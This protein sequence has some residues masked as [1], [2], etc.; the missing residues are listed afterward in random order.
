MR[1]FTYVTL[2]IVFS[3]VTFTNGQILNKLKKA[4]KDGVQE[5]VERRV[6]H[7]I[8]KAAQKQTDKYLEQLFGA[9]TQYEGGNYDYGEIMKNFNMNVDHADSYSFTGY[10]DMEISGT[11]QKGKAIDPTMFRSFNN[12][13]EQIW[14]MELETDEK[15][16][17]KTIMIFDNNYEAT[18][19]LMEDKKGEKSRMAYGIDWNSMMDVAMSSDSVQEA[20]ETLEIVTTENT[21]QIMGY[22]CNE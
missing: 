19:L 9:P 10:T 14:A 4:A 20:M 21:R 5:A 12:S 8:E 18:V 6:S 16:L 11:D 2:C 3:T 1:R 7:E 22:M 17:E 15:D 13:D